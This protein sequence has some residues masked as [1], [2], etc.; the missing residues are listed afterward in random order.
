MIALVA[1]LVFAT[2]TVSKLTYKTF[3]LSKENVN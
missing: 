3:F 2:V 1:A